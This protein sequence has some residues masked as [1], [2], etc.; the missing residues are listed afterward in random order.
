MNDKYV[1]RRALGTAPHR[2][3]RRAVAQMWWVPVLSVLALWGATGVTFAG[4]HSSHVWGGGV[5]QAGDL[6]VAAAALTWE[7]PDQN[8]TG[9]AASLPGLLLAPG[10]T[11]ILRQTVTP[12][13]IGDNLRVALGVG[14]ASLPPGTVGTWH[15]EVDDVQVAPASG[16]ASLD[17]TLLVPSGGDWV[18]VASLTLPAGDPVWVDPTAG[19]SPEPSLLLGVMTVTAHQVRC[20]DGFSVAC[21]SGGGG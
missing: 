4:W 21:S 20:G 15:V 3:A 12:T 8:A 6:Q 14:F 5:I 9:D 7:C 13:V 19:P 18:V 10:E 2:P 1:A 17:E 16:D 11:V